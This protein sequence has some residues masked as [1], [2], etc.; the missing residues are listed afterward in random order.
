MEN[1]KQITA[2]ATLAQQGSHWDDLNDPSYQWRCPCMDMECHH[3]T[4]PRI[5]DLLVHMEEEHALSIVQVSP[6]RRN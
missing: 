6:A 5:Q 1:N 4:F 3:G 2:S